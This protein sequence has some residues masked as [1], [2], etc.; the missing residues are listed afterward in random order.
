MNLTLGEERRHGEIGG[1]ETQHCCQ[2]AGSPFFFFCFSIS[3]EACVSIKELN[4]KKN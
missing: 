4:L 1:S 3:I 2:N